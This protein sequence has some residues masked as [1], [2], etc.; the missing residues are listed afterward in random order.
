MT[1]ILLNLAEYETKALATAEYP[2]KGNNALYPALKLNGE[3]GEVAEKIGKLWRNQ[4]Q[5][6]PSEY[7]VKDKSDIA[8]ELGDVLWYVNALANE[9]GYH[10]HEIAAINL[11]KLASRS[12]R[13]VIKST[14]DNR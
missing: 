4:G 10:L 11:E 8:N 14:G 13:G 5:K 6:C 7:S 3:A 9:I 1:E 12:A 2:D